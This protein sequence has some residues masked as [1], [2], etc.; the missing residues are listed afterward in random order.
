M[1]QRPM[2][3]VATIVLASLALSVVSSCGIGDKQR[4]ADVI[5]ATPAKA[6]ALKTAAGTL[7]VESK[8]KPGSSAVVRAEGT[9]AA[10]AASALGAM[11]N[12][13]LQ[14]PVRFDFAADRTDVALTFATESAE[15]AEEPAEAPTEPPAEAPAED[16]APPATGGPTT[17]YERNS[18][19]VQR[20]NRRP[21]ERRV[22][23]RLDFGA[24]PSDE[25]PPDQSDVS[26]TERLYTLANTINPRYL[27]DLAE[28]TLAGSVELVGQE[29][30]GGVRT[31][32]YQANVSIEK[33][34]TELDLTEAEVETRH[35]VFRLVGIG[36]DVH[37][38]EYWIDD[39]GRLR[40]SRFAFEQRLVPRVHNEL[41]VTLEVAQY[42]EPVE[43]LA[44]TKDETVRV[45]RYGR[46]IRAS[47]PRSG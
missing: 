44:P 12:A 47:I 18:A 45:D 13:T 2:R 46:F 3:P 27:L 8:P 43:V 41:T 24:L 16:P 30:V 14:V 40:R 28:G 37:R 19:Y 11:G 4:Q 5:T 22:W 23:A 9:Q 29:D 32:H 42:G 1:V 31:R 21:A 33:A 26:A 7:T 17:I 36:G 34:T 35:H 39:E 15:P 20:V 25:A 6:V 38:A 10:A